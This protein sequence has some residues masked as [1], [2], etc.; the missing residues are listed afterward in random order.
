MTDLWGNTQS[1]PTPYWLPEFAPGETAW[2]PMKGFPVKIPSGQQW[3]RTPSSQRGGL[4]SYINRYA[5]TRAGMVASYQDMIDRMMMMFPK[6]APSRAGRW[7][8]FKQ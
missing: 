2:E 5:G 7:A 4:Q 1:P 3:A 8:P 6:N